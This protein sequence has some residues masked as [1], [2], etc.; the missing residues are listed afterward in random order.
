MGLPPHASALLLH[1]PWSLCLERFHHRLAI[2]VWRLPYLLFKANFS[3]AG[4]GQTARTAYLALF[5]KS[6]FLIKAGCQYN[7]LHKSK[8][9]SGKGSMLCVFTS[10]QRL[11]LETTVSLGLSPL[12]CPAE[13][14]ESGTPLLLTLSQCWGLE[15]SNSDLVQAY[16]LAAGGYQIWQTTHGTERQ[17]TA[18]PNAAPAV[19]R[20]T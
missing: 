4:F 9:S 5:T 7:S 2:S 18:A 3:K 6:L 12:R 17:C 8:M 19:W 10:N 1:R 15:G 20:P 14:N 13:V 16:P 11:R